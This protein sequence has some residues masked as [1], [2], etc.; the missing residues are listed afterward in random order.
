MANL[1][2]RMIGAALL[3]VKT[4]EEVEADK[5][6]TGQAMIVVILLQRSEGG[7]LGIFKPEVQFAKKTLSINGHE[8]PADL[9]DPE[10]CKQIYKHCLG[11]R[12]K[13]GVL[14]HAGFF[15]GPQKFYDALNEMSEE[16]RKCIY[17]TSVLNV[18]QL[19]DNKYAKEALKILQRMLE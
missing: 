9:S 19:Y 2:Q 11:D 13:Q 14:I 10:H 1:T 4:Y 6:A 7:G 5:T 17:M 16:E 12:L 3:D 8:I 15:L 18:N